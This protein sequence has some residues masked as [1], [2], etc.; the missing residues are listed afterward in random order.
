M[1]FSY[2]YLRFYLTLAVFCG[3]APVANAFTLNMVTTTAPAPNASFQLVSSLPYDRQVV[4][5]DPQTLSLTFSQPPRAE[6]SVIKVLDMYGAQVDNGEVAAS[7]PNLY[8][9]LPSLPP[10]KYTVKWSA[11]CRCA[12]DTELGDMFHF[13]VKAE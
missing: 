8:T 13:T 11:H 6:R 2:K 4:A 10:G 9:E 7:G 1:P 12:D 3:L 5:G